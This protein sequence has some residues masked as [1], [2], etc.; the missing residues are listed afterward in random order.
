[1]TRPALAGS[2][3]VMTRVLVVD[4]SAT[5]RLLLSKQLST[6][7]AIEVV[8]SARDGLDALEKISELRP[9]V[10]TLDIEMPRLDGLQALER[11]MREQPTPVVMVSSLTREGAESTLRA[12]ELGAV[13]F[14][15]KPTFEAGREGLAEAVALKVRSAATARLHKRLRPR[16][17]RPSQPLAERQWAHKLVVVGSST[18]GPAALRV[19][20]G[21]FPP[22][23][24]VPVLV[25]Q[26]MPAGFTHALAASLDRLSELRVVEAE[27]GSPIESGTAL[28]APGGYHMVVNDSSTVSLTEDAPEC[29]VRPAINVTLESA[30]QQRGRNVVAAI[31]TGMGVDGTRGAELV[32]RAGGHVIT[33]AEETC[34]IHGMPRSVQ[35]AGLSDEE[36]PLPDV[37]EALV[38]QCLARAGR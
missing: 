15:E 7:P 26:H 17:V 25:V 10:V 20:F 33:E 35:E 21:S 14:I 6:D 5:I 37:A 22:A 12:L 34:V 13:D 31:L 27:E 30:V 28:V 11:I 32:K 4:D 1:M 3:R 8:G 9:D 2:A 24:N 23:M 38:H 18:G 16:V 19:L 29:G 36:Q